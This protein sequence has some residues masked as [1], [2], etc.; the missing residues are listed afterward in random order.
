MSVQVSYQKQFVFGFLLLIILLLVLEGA[1]RGYEYF[2]SGECLFLGNEVLF[3]VDY[4]LQKQMCSDYFGLNL[5]DKKF[6]EYEPNQ[7]LPTINI[8]S[9]GFRGPEITLEKPENTFRIFVVGGSTVFGAGNTS[10][11]TTLSGFLQQKFD[12]SDLDF[13][14]EVI[15][16][17][18]PGSHS[19]LDVARIKNNY[20]NFDPD[21]ILIYSG[22]NDGRI[23]EQEGN[24]NEERYEKYYESKSEIYGFIAKN[25]KHYRTLYLVY[26]QILP[27]LEITSINNEVLERNA[28]FLKDRWLDLC[29]FGNKEGFDTVI[30]IQPM[31]GTGNKPLTANELENSKTSEQLRILKSLQ[32]FSEQLDDLNSKCTQTG[33]LRNVFD[34]ISEPIFYDEGHIGNMGNEI[35]SEKLY[36][37]ILPI[38][39][40]KKL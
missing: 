38:L 28:I 24:T 3:N 9:H 33:D 20:V 13:N 27:T 2:I 40:N 39:Q 36:E 29:E 31:T 10:D 12:N 35:I 6:I 22:W 8:N 15:N 4:K 14:V 1:V 37:L 5:Q 18:I 34:N 7:H 17:G 30:T 19:V 26:Q 25:L 23:K 11:E 21:L 32:L 16:A